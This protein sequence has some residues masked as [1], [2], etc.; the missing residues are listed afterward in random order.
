MTSPPVHEHPFVG[1]MRGEAHFVGDHDHGHALARQLLHHL[2]HLADE[3]RVEGR[4]RLVEIHHMRAHRERPRDHGALLLP[5]R[6]LGREVVRLV[7]HP[8]LSQHLRA[9]LLGFPPAELPHHAQRLGDIAERRA[10]RPEIVVLKD[11]ADDAA[12]AVDIALA[13][14][15]PFAVP[16]AVAEQPPL[17][18]H[19][20]LVIRVEKHRGTRPGEVARRYG[21]S[22]N[23]VTGWRG[24]ARRGKLTSPFS[25]ETEAGAVAQAERRLATRK[26]EPS[27]AASSAFAAFRAASRDW[28]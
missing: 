19:P 21:L 28:P 20:P 25:L 9:D 3:F 17:D 1:D 22:V 7:T 14:A 23:Q 2:E 24:L 13:V 26:V 15:H 8:D 18:E 4:G 10:V 5:A 12:H 27:P 6:E 16:L 11:H